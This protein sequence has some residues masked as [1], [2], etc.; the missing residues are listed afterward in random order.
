MDEK[1][2]LGD[3]F[4]RAN[5]A[6]VKGEIFQSA[7]DIRL[8]ISKED[9]IAEIHCSLPKLYSKM[10]IYALE[11]EIR[12]VYELNYVRILPKYPSELFSER[13]IVFK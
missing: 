3:I 6:G 12:S 7:S 13:Y 5:P 4:K 11:E 10:D 8:R 2:S 9:R 1:K